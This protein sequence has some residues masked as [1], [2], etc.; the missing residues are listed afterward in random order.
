M[1]MIAAEIVEGMGDAAFAARPQE[2]IIAWNEDAQRLLG[3]RSSDVLGRPCHQVLAGRDVFGNEF[4][5]ESCALVRMAQS[6]EAIARFDVRYRH[7]S[8]RVVPVGVSIVVIP[9]GSPSQVD[10]IHV[11]DSRRLKPAKDRR[12]SGRT[13]LFHDPNPHR[14]E[15][16]SSPVSSSF[17]LTRREI[18]V[19]RLMG[20]GFGTRAIAGQLNISVATT[21][22]H[23]QNILNRL[24]V[25]SR[26]EAVSV[27]RRC[28]LI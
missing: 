23:I 22:N 24:E 4:C 15:A 9:N 27:A 6:R 8:G 12:G 16:R 2:G 1:T 3:Y 21:R 10:L 25:H 7:K 14:Q 18:E 19:L 13:S 20:E 5:C 26:L 28:C 11:L 17:H